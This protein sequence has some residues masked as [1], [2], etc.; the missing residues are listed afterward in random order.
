MFG[1][2]YVSGDAEMTGLLGWILER[3]SA[4]LHSQ[5]GGLSG[6][7]EGA[8]G[9]ITPFSQEDVPVRV[10]SDFRQLKSVAEKPQHVPYCYHPGNLSDPF[11]QHLLVA[12]S[13]D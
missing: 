11:L 9:L 4:F 5:R 10:K 8:P 7:E 13:W 2:I 12:H 3:P 1:N 6:P